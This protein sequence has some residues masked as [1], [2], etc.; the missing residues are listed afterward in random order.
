MTGLSDTADI[1]RG[2]EGGGVD[3]LVKPINPDELIA[4]IAAHAANARMIAGARAALE[5]T[6]DAVFAIGRD[7]TF[8]WTSAA[9]QTQLQ[10][11]T[12]EAVRDWFVANAPSA[13]W[14]SLYRPPSLTDRA[15]LP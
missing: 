13:D 8:R 5:A 14:L 9:A 15:R 11:P 3:Y 12:P 1:L 10:A 6:G 7:G 4:R 2:F